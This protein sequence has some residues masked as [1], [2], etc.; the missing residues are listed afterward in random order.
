VVDERVIGDGDDPRAPFC[1]STRSAARSSDSS[2]RT[3]PP[4]RAQRPLAG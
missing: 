4:G 1:S 3:K 2:I